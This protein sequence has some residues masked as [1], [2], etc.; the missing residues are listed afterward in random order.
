MVKGITYILTNDTAVQ[1]LVGRNAA[2]T[3]YKA[4]PNICDQPEKSPYSIVKQTK[5]TPIE[6]KGSIPTTYEYGYDVLTFHS[7]YESCE[8][9]DD[10]VVEA[11]IKLEGGTFNTVVFQDIRHTNT[12]DEYAENYKLHVKISSFEAMVNEDQTT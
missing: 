11:L 1:T 5:K 8:E 2:N 12:R 7:S 10:A 6:C 4:Y 9:L 3:K